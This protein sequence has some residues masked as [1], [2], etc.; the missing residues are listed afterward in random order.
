MMPPTL[1]QAMNANRRAA[2]VASVLLLAAVAGCSSPGPIT[3]HAPAASAPADARPAHLADTVSYRRM[4]DTLH[5]VLREAER[6]WLEAGQSSQAIPNHA[7]LLRRLAA[8]I[9][10]HGAEFSFALRSRWPIRPES[11]PQTE[12]EETSLRRLA[13]NPGEAVY[14]DEQLGGRA[15]FTAVFPVTARDRRCVD[16]HNDLPDS[17]KRDLRRGELMGAL[18]IRLPREF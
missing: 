15:Y 11:A 18:V 8:N 6:T 9:A 14:A 12:L 7:V 2:R 16:C 3:G 13:E 10:S 1:C 5:A 17:P 4:A